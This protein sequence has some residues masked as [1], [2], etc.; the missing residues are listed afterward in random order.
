MSADPSQRSKEA[1]YVR[2]GGGHTAWGRDHQL[3]SAG[4]SAPICSSKLACQGWSAGSSTRG[5]SV[6]R[7]TVDEAANRPITKQP[8]R[9][10]GRSLK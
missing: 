5:R 8:S 9:L 1:A 10:A 2:G 7:P 4:A 3:H 6:G